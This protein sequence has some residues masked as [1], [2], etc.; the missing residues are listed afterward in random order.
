MHFLIF[1]VLFIYLSYNLIVIH[2]FGLPES[3]SQ[4]SYLFLN[5][6]GKYYMFTI[7]CISLSISLLPT[8]I[9]ISPRNLRHLVYLSL[10]GLLISGMTPMFRTGIQK[11]IHYISAAISFLCYILWFLSMDFWILIENAILIGI[12][13]LI[14]PKD[15]VYHAET[16]IS[17][18][19]IIYLLCR[20]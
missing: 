13:V 20:L 12:L 10:G 15:Y 17:L 18:T 19:L 3:L 4:T 14:N 2:K 5:H 1:I 9:S 8:W 6:N 7:F 16:V 11:P